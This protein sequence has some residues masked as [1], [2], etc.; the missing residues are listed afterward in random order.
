MELKRKAIFLKAL[1][2]LN[3]SLTK[4][5]NEKF[6]DYEELRDSIIQRFEYCADLF[7]KYLNDHIK[8]NLGIKVEVAR[9]KM[10]FRE[11]FNSKIITQ[12]EL[13]ICFKLV[14]DRNLTSNTYNEELAEEICG[15]IKNYYSPMTNVAQRIK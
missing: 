9:P 15:R 4:L 5:D 7:W 14:E 3:K 12:D 6:D 11:S 1:E 10:V 2:T 8:I 13:E